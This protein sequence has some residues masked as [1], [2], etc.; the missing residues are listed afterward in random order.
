MKKKLVKTIDVLSHSLLPEM[1][2]LSEEEKSK[3][4]KKYSITEAQLPVM[5]GSDP[6]AIALKASPGDVVKITRKGETGEYVGY[7]IVTGD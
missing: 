3:V 1:D 5:L 4:L 7:R 6:A 2:V